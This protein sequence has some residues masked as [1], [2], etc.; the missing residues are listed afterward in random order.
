MIM[1]AGSGPAAFTQVGDRLYLIDAGDGVRPVKPAADVRGIAG[2]GADGDG[3]ARLVSPDGPNLPASDDS[4]EGAALNVLLPSPSN[5]DIVQETGDKAGCRVEVGERP[6]AAQAIA[7]LR[8]QGISAVGTNRAR[9]INRFGP[10][11]GHQV[12]QSVAVALG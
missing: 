12:G 8:E 5:G 2:I 10:R 6:L 7:V 3:E 11:V 1:R 9:V 4:V